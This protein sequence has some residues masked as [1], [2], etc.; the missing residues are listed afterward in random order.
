MF[1]VHQV[2]P[3][4]SCKAQWKG[5]EDKADKRRGGKTTS[6]NGEAWRS[7]SPRGQWRTEKMEKT[8]CKIICGAPTTLAVKGLMMMMMTCVQIRNTLTDRRT[9]HEAQ[10]C[11][12]T[13]MVFLFLLYWRHFNSSWPVSKGCTLYTYADYIWKLVHLW[14]VFLSPERQRP[15]LQNCPD[16]IFS[17]HRTSVFCLLLSYSVLWI[18]PCQLVSLSPKTPFPVTQ[19]PILLTAYLDGWSSGILSVQYSASA[20]HPITQSEVA[21][22]HTPCQSKQAGR[23]TCPLKCTHI[24][25]GPTTSTD[26]S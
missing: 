24:K 3:K 13:K 12:K 17:L 9:T 22:A 16:Y 23:E 1:P 21:L 18:P 11:S 6:G 7:A 5:K 10:G 14:Y 8:G 26:L 20:R 4:P 19:R 25:H 2:W 15:G